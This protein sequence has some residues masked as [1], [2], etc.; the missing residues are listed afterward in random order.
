MIRLL[1]SKYNAEFALLNVQRD[2]WVILMLRMALNFHL[3]K[4]QMNQPNGVF[5]YLYALQLE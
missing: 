3:N 2:E 5:I 1:T 4:E